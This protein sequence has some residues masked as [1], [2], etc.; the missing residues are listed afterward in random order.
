VLSLRKG[1]DGDL[2]S[3]FSIKL[4]T[5]TRSGDLAAVTRVAQKAAAQMATAAVSL[6][7][8]SVPN[9]GKQES[10]SFDEL[11]YGMGEF[12]FSFPLD[13]KSDVLGIHNEP[14]V[15]REKVQSLE[16][17]VKEVINILLKQKE[18]GWRPVQGEPTAV[19][20]NN[21][22]GL[23][24]LEINVVAE[25]VLTQLHATGITVIRSA[26]GLF[27]TSLDA[28]GFSVTLL[29]LDEELVP[30]LDAPTTAPGW[31]REMS[32][33]THDSLKEQEIKAPMEQEPTN[34]AQ[35]SISGTQ[36]V[37]RRI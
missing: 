23:S 1:K 4:L 6:D 28:P 15:R 12:G 10:L 37:K 32:K 5:K 34:P 3:G 2:S 13:L 25:E 14:G 7:R 33:V 17:V 19:L 11:E 24:P 26:A 20:I 30:L 29:K 31:P 35:T 22:G 8:C 36:V 18:K 27:V 9:R 21:L 16:T